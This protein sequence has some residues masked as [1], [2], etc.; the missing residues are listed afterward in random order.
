M[1][2]ELHRVNVL[3]EDRENLNDCDW[4]LKLHGEFPYLFKKPFRC[5]LETF[6]KMG[7]S[8]LFSLIKELGL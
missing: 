2:F 8:T 1:A 4:L 7:R 5:H 6:C 3:L